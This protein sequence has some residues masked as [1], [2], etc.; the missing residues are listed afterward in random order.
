MRKINVKRVRNE[1]R[2]PMGHT[3]N[4]YV[5]NLDRQCL[6]VYLVST[7]NVISLLLICYNY[8]PVIEWACKGKSTEKMQCPLRH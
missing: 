7:I 4:R 1:T 2:R 6:V 8:R 3:P 5:C